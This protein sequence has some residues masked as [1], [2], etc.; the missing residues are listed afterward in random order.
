MAEYSTFYRGYA[1]ALENGKWTV[2]KNSKVVATFTDKSA[3]W[4]WIDAA[5]AAE[6]SNQAA[7]SE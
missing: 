6:R 5:I 2:R 1:V 4:S 3:P 7:R